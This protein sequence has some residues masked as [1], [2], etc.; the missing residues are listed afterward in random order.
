GEL[1]AFWAPAARKPESGG[2]TPSLGGAGAV[3]ARLRDSPHTPARVKGV[4]PGPVGASPPLCVVQ[5]GKFAEPH[6]AVRQKCGPRVASDSGGVW[7]KRTL[8]LWKKS[9]SIS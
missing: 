4:R 5:S 8:S 2:L 6:V 9:V 7:I 1:R 3:S